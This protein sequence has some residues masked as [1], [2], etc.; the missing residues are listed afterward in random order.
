MADEAA[1]TGESIEGAG[2]PDTV[3]GVGG[4]G[5]VGGLE[6]GDAVP[7]DL[8][9]VVRDEGDCWDIKRYRLGGELMADLLEEATAGRAPET[10]WGLFEFDV[11]EDVL[12]VVTAA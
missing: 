10:D 2:S 9:G 6:V 3:T 7:A 4:N 8:Q 5:G 1:G 12:D 11:N